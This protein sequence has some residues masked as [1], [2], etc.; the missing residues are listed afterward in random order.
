VTDEV[1]DIAWSFSLA[2]AVLSTGGVLTSPDGVTWTPQNSGMTGRLLAV[3][4]NGGQFVAVGDSGTILTSPMG[5][6][7]RR[8]SPAGCCA[9][10]DGWRP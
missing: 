4:W 6:P 1:D 2:V 7:G 3:T 10:D 5:S 9:D 8:A